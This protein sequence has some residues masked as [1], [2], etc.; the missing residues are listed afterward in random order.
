L[1]MLFI[2]INV[3]EGIDKWQ[4][5]KSLPQFEDKALPVSLFDEHNKQD[6]QKKL[7]ALSLFENDSW[8]AD[9]IDFY[10]Q[11]MPNM[12]VIDLGLKIKKIMLSKYQQT[13]IT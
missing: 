3:L 2:L 5:A 7:G 12:N 1:N 13:V 11:D 9:K 10:C 8:F 4:A 6:G